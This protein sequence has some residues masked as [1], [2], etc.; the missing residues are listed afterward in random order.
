MQ[1]RTQTDGLNEQMSYET[2]LDCSALP[3]L[4]RQEFKAETDVNNILA[5]YGID[6]VKRQPE[7]GEVDFNLDLQTSLESIREAERALRKLPTELRGK[8]STWERLLDGAFNGEFKTDLE[9][10]HAQKAADEAAAKAQTAL[11]EAQRQG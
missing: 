11:D 5:R 4:A 7:Y 10:Y 6:G 1:I 8:Y 9:S 2:G 3:D